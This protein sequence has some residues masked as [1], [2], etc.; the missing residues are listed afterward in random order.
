M[1][2]QLTPLIALLPALSAP[3][4]PCQDTPSQDA[5]VR[6]APTQDAGAQEA[7]AQTRLSR[8]G[9]DGRIDLGQDDGESIFGEP[10]YVNGLRI[11]DI[12]IKRFLCYGRGSNG[13]LARRLGVLMD[14]E[15]T[16]REFKLRERLADELFEETSPD[17]LSDAQRTEVERYVGEEMAHLI[18]PESDVQ[19][20]LEEYADEFTERYPTLDVDTETRRAYLSVDWYKDQVRQTMAFDQMFFPGHPDDW[21]DLSREAVQAGAPD[22]DLLADYAEQYE[23]RA[24]EA[25]RTGEPMRREEEMMMLILRDYVMAGLASLVEIKTMSSGLPP[26]VLMTIGGGGQNTELLTEEVYDE[27]APVFSHK[28]V[29]D[30]KAFLAMYYAAKDEL[31]R[32]GELI[33][34]EEWLN[35]ISDLRERLS[36][37]LFSFDFLALQGHEYPSL[38]YYVEHLWLLDSY[39]SYLGDVLERDANNQL[40]SELQEHLPKANVIMG[41]GK[42]RAQVLLVSAFDFPNFKWKDGGWEVAEERAFQLRAEVD[43]HIDELIQA[44]EERRAAVA[45]GQNYQ[46]RPGLLSFDEFW[47]NLLDLN[48][49]FW[50]PPMPISGKMPPATGMRNKGRFSGEPKTRNDFKREIGE[51]SYTHFVS[52]MRLCDM[53]FFELTPG[54]VG[55]PYRGPRGYYIFY[56]KERRAPTNPIDP[57][58]NERHFN[59][60]VEDY[61]RQRFTT[62]CHDLL[63]TQ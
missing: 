51:S 26:T 8:P 40:T 3:A 9:P 10:V 19:A 1:K 30:A 36:A 37:S 39:K 54:E 44:D 61:L 35:E 20:R 59:M 32:V 33:E 15:R 4:V 31:E 63:G 11:P 38:E 13:L 60:L 46:P 29:E 42:C 47:S 34:R 17:G 18:I 49:D 23:Y 53:V 22:V 2:P 21:P 41:L 24:A 50:D 6:E 28:D 52:N 7:A 57:V 16:L 5:P 48:S 14:Q 58:N 55:G 27:M 56:L 25:E 12:D 62:W 45:A 43:A